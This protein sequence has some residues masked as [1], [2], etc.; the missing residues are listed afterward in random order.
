VA[1]VSYP[2]YR[3][4]QEWRRDHAIGPTF[5][6]PR[7]TLHPKVV[8]AI[9]VVEAEESRQREHRIEAL[10]QNQGPGKG[11]RRGKTDEDEE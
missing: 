6:A 2:L 5:A 10:R 7:E 8:Q 1:A 9:Q 4:A 11:G 3:L